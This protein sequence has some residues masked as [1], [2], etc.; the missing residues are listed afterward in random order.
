MKISHGVMYPDGLIHGLVAL[1][2]PVGVEYEEGQPVSEYALTQN[3][4]NPFNPSTQIK[5]ALKEVRICNS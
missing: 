3:Y 4:P 1:W 2:D 5:F